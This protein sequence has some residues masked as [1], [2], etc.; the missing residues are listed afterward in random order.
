MV[1]D[2]PL[3]QYKIT[4][5]TKAGKQLKIRLR[6]KGNY[7]DSYTAI[8]EAGFTGITNYKIVVQV[9]DPTE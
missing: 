8:F 2:I 9:T 3:G 4:A 1:R 7:Q 6:N 5:K